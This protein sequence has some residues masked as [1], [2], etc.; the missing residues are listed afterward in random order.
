MP[1]EERPKKLLDQVRE[2][3]R[4]KHYSYRTEKSYVAWIRRYILF[5]GKRHPAAMG[6]KD[7]ERFLSH[8]AVHGNVAAATQNQ[9]FNA[10]LF[11]Y[12]DI[13]NVEFGEKID[14]IR[15]KKPKRLPVV[16]SP[17]EVGRLFGAMKD[18]PRLMCQLMYG[19]GLRTM[20]CLRLRVK[21][22]DF[23][24]NHIVVRDGKGAKDRI[25]VFPEKLKPDIAEQVERVKMV[26]RQ[27]LENGAGDAYLPYALARKY[28]HAGRQLGWQYAFP[29]DS[30][31]QDPRSGK[32]RRH[33]MDRSTLYK[34]VG[35]ARRL[36]GIA[37]PV[38]CHTLR[39]S[40]ATRLLEAGT[41]IRTVQELLGH[42]DV[43]TTMIYTHVLNRP[44]ISVKSPLDIDGV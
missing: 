12:R 30:L 13:L 37:K 42:A 8:L 21:D 25:T 17:S 28:R 3:L 33:H 10:I 20:E 29:S 9:A 31:S 11:L 27:D 44:G 22:L 43:S 26:H 38:S 24:L 18:V 5:H 19:S 23:D 39:H 34:A 16:M 6:A 2:K 15:A 4:L 40:F 41:D 36:A 14:A 32:T 7:V 35:R 1:M